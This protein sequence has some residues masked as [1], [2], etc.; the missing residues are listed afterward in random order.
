MQYSRRKGLIV[1]RTHRVLTVAGV[2]A[3][4]S[5]L[6][7]GCATTEHDTGD[8]PT[9]T[10]APTDDTSTTTD[11]TAPDR[12]AQSTTGAPSGPLNDAQILG[13]LKVANESEVA[14]GQLAVQ[15]AMAPEVRDFAQDM[16]QDHLVAGQQVDQTATAAPPS[17]SE[18]ASTM[19]REANAQI[20]SL[21]AQTGTE[22]DRAY[23]ESQVKMH[24]DLLDA[25]V[26]EL[27]PKAQSTAVRQ[28]LESMRG[29]VGEHLEEARELKQQVASLAG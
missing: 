20:E 28:L 1:H 18:M 17:E 23:V 22:F 13:V 3:A 12:T 14:A 7:V 26:A 21:N 27:L 15:K 9:T 6:L 11:R 4:L 5:F 24:Q 29:K 8:T 25:I 19:L 10:T 2:C 16:V